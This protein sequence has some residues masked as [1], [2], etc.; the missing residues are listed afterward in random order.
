MLEGE[1]VEVAV[2]ALQL[3]LTVEHGLSKH[4]NTFIAEKY[5]GREVYTNAFN[6]IVGVICGVSNVE[7]PMCPLCLVCLV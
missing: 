5:N 6:I 7:C 3:T 4:I 2:D 1:G